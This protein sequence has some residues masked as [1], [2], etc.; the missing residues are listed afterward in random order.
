MTRYIF[1]VLIGIY[2]LF[3]S[4]QIVN[5]ELARMDENKNGWQGLVDFSFYSL[6]NTSTL[7]TFSNNINTQFKKDKNLYLILNNINIAYSD[8][9][10]FE[11][12][13]F[14]HLRYGRFLDSNFTYELFGQHQYDKIQLIKQRLLLGTGFRFNYFSKGVLSAY[15]GVSYM[16]E[17]E[18]ELKTQLIHYNQRMS[19]Y[20]NIKLTVKKWF[21][22]YNTT[23]YQPLIT[24]LSDFRVS[25]SNT[26]L[27]KI[28]EYLSFST[29]YNFSYDS[30]PVDDPEVVSY[31]HKFTTGLSI[32]L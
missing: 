31:I 15:T 5:V 26:L 20:S 16:F 10:K 3:A 1:L 4:S 30:K 17:Y 6:K 11:Q 24:N 14:Q 32:K 22:F 7:F 18:S 28:N 12:N 25:S 19:A 27:F 13:A 9:D 21:R 23:Y 8:I 29:N 2:P